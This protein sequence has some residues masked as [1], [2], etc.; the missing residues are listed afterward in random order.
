MTADL[1]FPE[2]IRRSDRPTDLPFL[3]D[4]YNLRTGYGVFTSLSSSHRRHRGSSSS[5]GDGGVEAVSDESQLSSIA[6]I[7]FSLAY[8]PRMAFPSGVP[9]SRPH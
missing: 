6:N 3:H 2:R 1:P 9:L 5:G 7:P 8:I 4:S